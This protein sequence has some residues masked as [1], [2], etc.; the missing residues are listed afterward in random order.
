MWFVIQLWP[1]NDWVQLLKDAK[2]NVDALRF[3]YNDP[4]GET[5]KNGEPAS[6]DPALP[7][8]LK[9]FKDL[10]VLSKHQKA[11][12]VLLNFQM[13]GLHLACMF[14]GTTNRDSHLVISFC[15]I[16]QHIC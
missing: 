4:V 16:F 3:Y 9:L 14:K 15:E 7:L 1:L 11:V 8:P 13:A 2:V 5:S 6:T 10:F 12:K